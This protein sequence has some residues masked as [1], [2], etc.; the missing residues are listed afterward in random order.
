MRVLVTGG[1]GF[2]GSALVRHL[3]R[4]SAHEILNLDKLTYAGSL[5]TVEECADDPRYR[6]VEA[7]ICDADAV[8]RA[9]ASFD[10]DAIVHLAAES[11]VDRSIDGPDAFIETNIVG[12]YRM[13]RAATAH[14]AK[15]SGERRRRSGSTTSR[16]TR[17]SDRSARKGFF[18]RRPPTTRAR[19]TRPPRQARIT[20]CGP[21]TTPTGCR[22]W[23]PIAP[24]ITAPTTSPRS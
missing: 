19:P 23:S 6:F 7:D 15:L 18:T 17:C 9:M 1:A 3:V 5:T 12:T 21:G 8:A 14:W 2:I 22:R 20:W 16:R 10:P 24:T 13:L 4:D 11:H